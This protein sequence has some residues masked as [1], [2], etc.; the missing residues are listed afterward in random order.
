MSFR[1]VFIAVVIAFALIVGAFLINRARPRVEIESAIGGV[2]ARHGQVRRVPH[3]A[4]SIR[5]STSTS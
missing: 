4:S 3:S 2:R 1:P 5:S